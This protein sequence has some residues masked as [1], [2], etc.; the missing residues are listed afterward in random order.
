MGDST[1]HL[2]S[3][4]STET[5]SVEVNQSKVVAWRL[6][7]LSHEGCEHQLKFWPRSTTASL[8][9]KWKGPVSLT[10]LQARSYTF[11]EHQMWSK[12]L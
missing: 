7:L 11:H 5:G 2:L 8:W 3:G 12:T 6:F 9:S 10:V 4:V 1:H